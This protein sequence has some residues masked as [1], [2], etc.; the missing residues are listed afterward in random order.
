MLKETPF[1]KSSAISR[2]AVDKII[3]AKFGFGARILN[4]RKLDGGMFNTTYLIETDAFDK[5]I[6][7]RAAPTAHDIMFSFE[8]VMMASEE[9]TFEKLAAADVP[10]PNVIHFGGDK[11]IIPQNYIMMEYIES[12][13]MGDPAIAECSTLI[14]RELGEIMKKVHSVK[15]EH[16]G[17]AALINQGVKHESWKDFL[18]SFIREILIMSD[19]YGFFSAAQGDEFIA[20]FND[21]PELLKLSGKPH[22]IH[23]D[24]W[25][26]NVLVSRN[27]E[28]E[29]HI[30]ALIDVDK[31]IYGDTEFEMNYWMTNQAF[32]SG[33]EY[34]FD[35][36]PAARARRM[37]Y[38]MILNAYKNCVYKVQ[39]Y[40][41]DA[42]ANCM[43][44][45]ENMM[46]QVREWLRI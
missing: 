34:D 26:A 38:R 10:V 20:L 24:L 12:V 28:G 33:Y 36:S 46:R 31:A 25:Y 30:A 7:M 1:T 40:F 19:G 2:D 42:P 5:K 22:M 29:W 27:P 45:H 18:V 32:M 4:C 37:M 17:F 9:Q 41:D 11:S 23:N 21:S 13:D 14:E 16:Y 44:N 39:F 3:K 15:G 6:I 8:K 35:M 43:K